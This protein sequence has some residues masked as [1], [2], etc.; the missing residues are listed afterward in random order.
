MQV[1]MFVGSNS[2][3][4]FYARFQ[5]WWFAFTMSSLGV[6]MIVLE[7]TPPPEPS[8]VGMVLGGL[9]AGLGAWIAGRARWRVTFDANGFAVRSGWRRTRRHSWGDCIAFR[10]L[11]RSGPRPEPAGLFVI[12]KGNKVLINAG[13]TLLRRKDLNRLAQELQKT[14][15]RLP[16][17]KGSPVVTSGFGPT[18]TW[19]LD[20]SN[21]ELGDN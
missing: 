21:G 15:E 11:D 6:L 13:A 20:W 9:F 3:H 14:F 2:Q 18:R 5:L 17:T 19:M 10:R 12:G 1:R 7:L 8:Y 4:A 16:L